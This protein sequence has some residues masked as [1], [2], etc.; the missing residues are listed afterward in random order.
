MGEK[1]RK[2]H[3]DAAERPA[4]KPAVSQGPNTVKVQHVENKGVVGPVLAATPGLSFPRTIAFNAYKTSRI[5]PKVGEVSELLLQTSEHPR[6]DYTAREEEDGS[7]ESLLDNYIGVFDPATG[8]LQVIP[9]RKVTVR[10]TLRSETDELRAQRE[11]EAAVRA[12]MTAK[13]HALAAEFGSKK[14]RKAIQEMAENAITSGRAQGPDMGGRDENVASAVLQ[15]MST[16]TAAMPTREDIAAAVDSSKPRPQANLAAE[17][18]SDVYPVETLVGKD[19]MTIIPI[20]DWVDAVDAGA[21]INVHSRYVAKRIVKLAKTKELQKLKVLRFILLCVDF[22]AALK[23][24]GKG[25][26]LIPHKEKLLR[27]MGENVPPSVVDAIRRKFASENNDLTR[28]HI[29]NLATHICAAALIVDNFRVDVNDLREDLKLENNEIKQYFHEIGCK[30]TKP[31]EAE[32]EKLKISKAE[33]TMHWMATLKIPLN[34]PKVKTGR[35][36]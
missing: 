21:A 32:R 26:K 28:W 16:T 23:A 14:S 27:E 15:G 8:K 18:P 30:V 1:K 24:K 10:S 22:N 4:K 3:D 35:R 2:R 33:A 36:R 25:P 34:F 9:V 13:R 5:L 29:D 11:K 31:T 19:L 17:Y 20:K 6:L 12:T 7:T